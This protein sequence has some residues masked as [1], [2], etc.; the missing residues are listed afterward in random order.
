[1]NKNDFDFE[2]VEQNMMNLNTRSTR[3]DRNY[4]RQKDDY[5]ESRLSLLLGAALIATA[6]GFCLFVFVDMQASANVE[7]QSSQIIAASDLSKQEL[8]VLKSEVK[9]HDH[10]H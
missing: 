7:A 2:L 6:I 8:K 5:H 3:A 4:H 10:K 1:M 9:K